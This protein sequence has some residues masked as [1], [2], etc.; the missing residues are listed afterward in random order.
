M[1]WSLPR[2]PALLGSL[3]QRFGWP[4]VLDRCLSLKPH[5]FNY[6]HRQNHSSHVPA[7]M[8]CS[9]ASLAPRVGHHAQS[10]NTR[11]VQDKMRGKTLMTKMFEVLGI[12]SLVLILL[13]LR[14]GT[15]LR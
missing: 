7:F 15:L 4:G 2:V 11:R 13:G 12:A 6:L 14:Y 9:K 3:A 8:H 1:V 10:P 5:L